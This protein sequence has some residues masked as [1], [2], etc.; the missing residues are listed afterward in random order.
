[1][2]LKFNGYF[3]MSKDASMIK[4]RPFQRFEPNLIVEKMPCLAVLNNPSKIP[5]DPDPYAVP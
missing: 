1:M 5:I 3:L 2:T 4:D